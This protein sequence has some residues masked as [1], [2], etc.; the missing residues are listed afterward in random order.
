MYVKTIQ[1]DNVKGFRQLQFDFE[2]PDGTF[3][4]WTVLVGGNAS[5]KSTLLKAISLALIG[6]D[7]GRQLLVS[8]AGWL[9]PNQS[10]AESLAQI[11]WDRSCDGFKT[12]GGLPP[13]VFEAGVRWAAE[14][15]QQGDA[16]EIGVP[17][18]KGIERRTI[19]STRVHPALRGPWDP[20]ARGWFCAG[21]GPMRRLSGGSQASERFSIVREA[22]SRFV[23]LFREDAALSESESWLRLNNSRQRETNSIE[24]A[25]LL[26]GA[27]DLL[28]DGLLP[29]GMKISQI[30]VDHVYVM[31]GRGVELP[32]RD[33]S[34]GCRSVYAT[35]LDLIHGMA[36]VYGA[37]GLFGRDAQNRVVVQRP[38]VVLID[39]IEAHLHPRWQMEIPEWLK[40]HFPQVQFI[41][42]T[43]SPMVAQAA[44]P[45][46]I[47][48][49]PSQDDLGRAP[50]RLDQHEYELIRLRRAEKTLLGAAFGLHDT[51]S[52]WA[53]DQIAAWQRLDAKSRSNNGLSV[54]ERKQLTHLHEQMQI[55]YDVAPDTVAS[56]AAQ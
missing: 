5:G 16:R 40:I 9:S 31:D 10:R 6:P 29:H 43:H 2:R 19:K 51:R 53:N 36:D 48:V 15:R 14:T 56:T 1:L 49:L 17:E 23:T 33:I 20:N 46:G 55:A 30:T 18:F 35:V 54:G 22:M 27:K 44:D 26:S 11:V 7:A 12:K 45:N 34:D 47:F 21:Y 50:R 39:E 3:P 24:L 41:V 32:M 8:P 13:H 37:V 25:A 4:G 52:K 42:S 28:G 38:G